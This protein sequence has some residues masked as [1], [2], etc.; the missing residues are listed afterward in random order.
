VSTRF[1]YKAKNK[2]GKTVKGLVEARGQKEA[3]AILRSRNLIVFSLKKV[4]GGI[5]AKF[6]V[7][8]LQRVMFSDLAAFTRQL[9]T[10]ITAGLAL[11]DSLVLLRDQAK[12]AFA[13]IIDDVLKTVEGG[14]AL[15]LALGNHK[16]VFGQVYI[17]SVKAGETGGVLDEVLKRLA[18][19]LEKQQEF[20]AK[21]KGA[22]IYP[23]IIVVGM[24]GVGAVMMIFVVPKLLSLYAEFG[25]TLPAPT[26]ALMAVSA[27]MSKFWWLVL[28]IML[29]LGWGFRLVQ[30][31]HEG[32]RKID[33]IKFK[34]PIFGVLA[35]QVALTEMTRTLALLVKTGIPIVD[36]LQVIAQGMGNLVFSEGLIEAS[37]KVEKGF[38]IATSLAEDP[39]FPPILTQMLAVGEETGQ[40]DEVLLKMSNYF[41]SESEMAVKALTTAIEPIIMVVLGVGVGFLIISIIMPMYNL[42]N[43]F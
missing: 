4:Q 42:T 15:S 30:K 18:D 5:L 37:R 14:G 38:P 10:M 13:R 9:S 43:Q 33:E 31:T 32:K 7:R 11:P 16:D 3:V 36:A 17:S 34:I 24:V 41:E 27:F 28:L 35:K 19:N 8:F 22:L 29:C 2:E 26:R 23:V 25:T 39:A 21:V 12:P 20:Q 1:N 6:S 40:L